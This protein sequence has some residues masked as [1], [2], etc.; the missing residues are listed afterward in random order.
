[1]NRKI[2]VCALVATLVIGAPAGASA[3]DLELTSGDK[4]QE[5]FVSQ[6][7]YSYTFPAVEGTRS[8]LERVIGHSKEH[9]LPRKH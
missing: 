8:E 1:M 4:P 5:E 3:I 9:L 7:S 6:E 2:F